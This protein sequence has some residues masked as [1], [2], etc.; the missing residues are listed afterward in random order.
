M[1]DLRLV[2]LHGLGKGPVG[3][4]RRPAG[5]EACGRVAVPSLPGGSPPA[6]DPAPDTVLIGHSLGG[7]HDGRGDHDRLELLLPAL[8]EGPVDELERD[9]GA[10]AAQERRDDRDDQRA[11]TPW[12]NPIT[13]V[14]STSPP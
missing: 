3:P 12:R 14:G 5:L 10:R 4:G 8:R 11:S 9:G 6:L 1:A 13:N 7:H 2:C